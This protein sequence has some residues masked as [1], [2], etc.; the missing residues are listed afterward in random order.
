[1]ISAAAAGVEATLTNFSVTDTGDVS[2]VFTAENPANLTSL[3]SK[4]QGVALQNVET[5]IDAD[6]KQLT[7][8]GIE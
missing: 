1:M 3:E 5:R 2:A 8:T 4:L 6:K 7:L